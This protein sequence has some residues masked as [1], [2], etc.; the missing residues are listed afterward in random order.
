MIKAIDIFDKL[1]K[2]L[3]RFPT[4]KEFVDNGYS[5][6]AYFKAKKTYKEQLAQERDLNAAN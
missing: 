3:G 1:V 4:L 5:Q 2:E 6:R